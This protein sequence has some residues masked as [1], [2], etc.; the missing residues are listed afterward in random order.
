M[1]R[2][3]KSM[4]SLAQMLA[5]S[6]G[7][8]LLPK[9][10]VILAKGSLLDGNGSGCAVNSVAVPSVSTETSSCTVAVTSSFSVATG[11]SA[12]VACPIACWTAWVTVRDIVA[13][14]ACTSTVIKFC[15][16]VVETAP[17]VTS[18]SSE[19]LGLFDYDRVLG[20]ERFLDGITYR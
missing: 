8:T 11:V 3:H 13:D 10:T 6:L 12:L 14:R 7:L 16:G 4:N 18:V 5:L 9:A 19:A 2:V 15:G 17:A 1:R 20:V